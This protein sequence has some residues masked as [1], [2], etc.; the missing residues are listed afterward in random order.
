MFFC[1]ALN[2]LNI[3]SDGSCCIFCNM[4][5]QGQVSWRSVIRL[6][7]SVDYGLRPNPSCIFLSAHAAN[8]SFNSSMIVF[9]LSPNS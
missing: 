8:V 7:G 6:F 2:H 9:N 4:C 3:T 1:E 5:R